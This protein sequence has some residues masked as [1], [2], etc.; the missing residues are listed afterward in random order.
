MAG[1][2]TLRLY[3]NDWLAGRSDLR[4]TTRAKY[5]Y[6]LDRHILPRL[7]STKLSTLAP[8]KVRSWFHELH[9]EHAATA[10]DAYRLLR[11]ALNTAKADHQIAE[12]PCQV[13]GAGQVRSPERPVASVIEVARAVEAVPERYRLA[14]LLSAWCQLRRG[15][16]LALQRRHVDLLHGR[17]TVEQAWVAPMGSKPI[18]GPPKTEAGARSLAIPSNVLPAVIDH[19][20]RFVR[21]APS[22]WLFGTSTGTALSP[23]NFQRAWS[24]ARS[25]A[26]RPDLHLHDLRHSGLTW[27]AASGASVADLMRRGGHANPRAALLYQHATQ[28]RDQA[29]ADALGKLGS[30]IVVITTPAER[31]TRT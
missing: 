4:D 9:S 25:I 10:D 6:L 16:V 29:L 7:G 31:A 23:R 2:V 19:L 13:K 11:A 17:I 15:E 22:A 30:E 21:P 5:R 26:G 12:N 8:S 3:A 14:L 27:A 28:D 24:K 20:E 18:I 1:K